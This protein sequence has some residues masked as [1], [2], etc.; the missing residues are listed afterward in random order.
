MAHE[1]FNA[2]ILE[3]L[4]TG[5]PRVEITGN[6]RVLIENHKGIL[7]YDETIMRVKC[8]GCEI[9]ITGIDLTL[10]ALSIDELAVNGTIAAVEFT[11]G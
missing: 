3:E 7:E 9:R 10:T 11:S 4:A 1:L 5:K 6:D 8:S 2:A